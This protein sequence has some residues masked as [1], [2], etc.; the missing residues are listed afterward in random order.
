MVGDL[1]EGPVTAVLEHHRLAGIVRQPAQCVCQPQQLLIL[2]CPLARAGLV[3]SER[4]FQSGR[5]A[6]Q[7]FFDR[8]LAIEVALG[9]LQVADG[10]GQGAGKDLAQPRRNDAGFAAAE[11]VEA[12]ARPKHRLLHHVRRIELSPQPGV[13][14]NGREHAQVPAERFQQTTGFGVRRHRDLP[15][16]EGRRSPVSCAAKSRDYPIRHFRPVHSR[17]SS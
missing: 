2:I 5:G 7:R 16:P 13:E 6:I 10:V 11:P 3:S 17:N 15:Y 12:D 14:V 8:F 9:P 4:S 1:G